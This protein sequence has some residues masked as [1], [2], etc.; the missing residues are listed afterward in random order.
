M[1]AGVEVAKPLTAPAPEAK[2]ARTVV[3]ARQAR[4]ADDAYI[5]GAREIQ[6]KNLAAA[7]LDF[8]RAVQLNPNNRDYALALLA[9]RENHITELVQSAARARQVGDRAQADALIAQA[10][11]LDPDNP[12]LA[13]HL[14]DDEVKSIRS[15]ASS[16]ADTLAG[17]IELA[18]TPGTHDF[19]LSGDAQSVLRQVYS[20]YGLTATFDPSVTSGHTLRFNVDG[21]NF[22]DA[23]RILSSMTHTFAVAVQSKSAL[24]AKDTQE[25][26][27]ALMPL[28]E[29]TLYIPGLTQDQMTELA[30]VARNVFDVK[31]VTASL[32][33]GFMLLRGDERVLQQVN[34]TYADLLDGGSEVLLDVKIYEIDK[35]HIDNIG[36]STPSSAS[37][38]SL[39]NEAEKIVAANQSLVNTALASG[40][41]TLTNNPSL[42]ILLEAEYLIQYGGVVDANISNLLGTVGIFS[43]IPLL[44]FTVSGTSTVNLSLTA[45][46]T[47]ML[48]DLQLRSGNHQ[49]ASFRIG[50]RYPI[51]TA[52]Y[53]NGLPSVLTAAEQALLKQYTGSTTLSSAAIPPQFTF[54]DLGITL[55]V[56]P[57][58]LRNDSVNMALD[59]KIES[60][61]GGTIQGNPIIN[62]RSLVSNV[63]V[64]ANQAAM[65]A[66][67]VS[68]NDLGSLSGLPGISDLPGFQ[69]ISDNGNQRDSGELLLTITPHI[70]RGGAMRIASRRLAA[71]RTGGSPGQ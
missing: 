48:D 28:I 63:T 69:D 11:A 67:V 57:H 33:G 39:Y 50:S 65:L 32:T 27:D 26:R 62:S 34:A 40:A 53:S 70:V 55:K 46:D 38:F 1:P 59:M 25:N 37:L 19:H 45:S 6:R 24:I 60:L 2:P 15:P 14:G 49:P 5:E 17:P 13:Q 12:I 43:G 64:P 21:V 68:S 71:V 42:N 56:T 10:R 51:V 52:S 20:A 44:G 8:A 35:T 31:Q 4:A 16:L 61:S 23:N 29:E 18:P 9:T 58:I 30:N 7:E 47:R 36:V 54:E 66:T 3:S 22:D 41:F